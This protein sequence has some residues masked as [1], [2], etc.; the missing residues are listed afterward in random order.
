MGKKVKK[1]VEEVPKC[2]NCGKVLL[3]CKCSENELSK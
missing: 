3:K 2:P 1:P